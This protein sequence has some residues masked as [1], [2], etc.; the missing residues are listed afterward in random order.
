M[1]S[2]MFYLLL[3]CL[4][5]SGCAQTS[6]SQPLRKA[7]EV[8]E[9]Q[10]PKVAKAK[11]V[12]PEAP[13]LKRHKN[14]H[15]T[16]TEPWAVDLKGKTWRVQAGYRCNGITAPKTIKQLL[17]DGPNQPTTW[18]AVFHDWLFTQPGMTRNQADR[19]FY[20]LMVAYGVPNQKAKLM[21]TSVQAYSIS[22]LL[23]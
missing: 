19:L 13:K 14:G 23:R 4:I 15:Y 17:G 8:G 7:I 9:E 2:R 22:R 20:D 12:R 1:K 5:H 11:A 6:H 10:N 21:H 16:V 3:V 18:A